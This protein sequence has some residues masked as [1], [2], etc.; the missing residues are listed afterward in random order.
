[1]SVPYFQLVGPAKNVE[2][3]GI[4]LLGIDTQNGRK[5]IFSLVFLAVLFLVSKLLRLLARGTKTHSGR[6]VTFWTR[7]GIS[8][9]TFIIGVL[10]FVSIWF[11][12]PTRLATGIG[13]LGAGLAFALQK[14]V[15]SFAGYFVILRGKTFNV[16]DRIT[17]GG[18]RGDVIA[19]NFIQT[20]IMEMVEPPSVQG[21]DPGM[22]VQS[23]QYSGRIVT[24]TNA[25]IFDEPVYNYTRDFPYLWEEIHIPVSYKDDRYEAERILLAAAEKE[26][27][28]IADLAEETLAIL[29]QRFSIRKLE[30]R[31]QV[32]MRLTDNW[33]ELTVRFL[34]KDH[35][36][37][38][39]KNRMSRDI[40]DN[41][42]KAKIGI[43]SGTYEIVGLP[44]IRVDMQR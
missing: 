22:W 11:D 32:F 36:I 44:P 26:T 16:G 13:L 41:L 17:M 4:R 34:C 42:D 12:N 21:S 20:V 27:V 9:L 6:T 14:V 37:R 30:L 24:V 38:G 35:D 3:F 19:L 29:E 43:A 31:P 28:K 18:V 1:M 2:L 8:L 23:R 25:K 33:V 5:L 10:G 7:Q 39:L 40:I 15:T